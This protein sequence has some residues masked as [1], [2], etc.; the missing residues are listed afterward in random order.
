MDQL[1]GVDL[2]MPETERPAYTGT[3][4]G[5]TATRLYVRL[6]APPVDIKVY[7]QDI[8]S[9]LG[10]EFQLQR[11]GVELASPDRPGVRFRAGDRIEL[12]TA[13]YDPERG[14]WHMVP[15]TPKASAT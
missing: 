12:R 10:L 4:M 11:D 3:V 1:L 13:A 2:K 9:R 14:R 6:D 5:L 8:Q 15:I 7:L